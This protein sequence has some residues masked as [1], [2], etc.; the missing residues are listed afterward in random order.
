MKIETIY[1]DLDD[2]L[3]DLQGP[4]FDLSGVSR[5]RIPEIEVYKKSLLDWSGLT[6]EVFCENWAD[7]G[8]DFW[9]GLEWTDIGREIWEEANKTDAEVIIVTALPADSNPRLREATAIGKM[10]WF[11]KVFH[12]EFSA[13]AFCSEK[14]KLAGPNK[15][16]IDDRTDFIDG[17]MARGGSALVVPQ[18][19]N[20]SQHDIYNIPKLIR[21]R[22]K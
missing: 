2:T 9:E 21:D 22:C 5:S 14:H 18:P 15:L 6:R 4:L 10:R 1:L 17:F 7:A 3:V 19:W 20:N 11:D 12:E 8:P 13:F 16:L